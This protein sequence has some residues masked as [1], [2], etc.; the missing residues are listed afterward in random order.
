MGGRLENNGIK[1]RNPHFDTIINYQFSQKLKLLGNGE[2]NYS[3]IILEISYKY[4]EQRE[5]T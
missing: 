3:T 1:L 5:T 4:R 2:F